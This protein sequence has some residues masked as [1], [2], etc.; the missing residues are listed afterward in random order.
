M[1]LTE[2][3]IS[4]PRPET[5]GER[6]ALPL[7]SWKPVTTKEGVLDGVVGDGGRGAF[8]LRPFF[9]IALGFPG[10]SL[11]YRMLYLEIGYR[12]IP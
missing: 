7:L 2:R 5:E 12:R 3:I 10:F 8:L 4:Q 6:R 1:I 9:Y 11:C